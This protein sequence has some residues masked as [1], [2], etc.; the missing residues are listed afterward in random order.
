VFENRVLR[1]IYECKREDVTGGWRKLQN[2]QLHNLYF[3]NITRLIK[4]RRMKWAGNVAHKGGMRS[5]CRI[6]VGK[7]EWKR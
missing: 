3:S 6:L 2:E 1:R 7:P 5:A 4:S